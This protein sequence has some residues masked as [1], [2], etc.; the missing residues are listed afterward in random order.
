MNFL[1]CGRQIIKLACEERQEII[2][3]SFKELELSGRP[4][5]P[6]AD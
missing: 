2:G 1:T 4:P 6:A 3:G 5:W